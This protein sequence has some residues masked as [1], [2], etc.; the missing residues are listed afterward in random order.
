M[1]TVSNSLLL[2]TLATAVLTSA[3]DS[4]GETSTADYAAA[5]TCAPG[6]FRIAGTIDGM[7]VDVTEPSAGGGFAQDGEGGNLGTQNN[8]GDATDPART[9]LDLD[10]KPGLSVGD[11][12]PA[13]GTVRLA[14]PNLDGA[15]LCLGAGSSVRAIEDGVQFHLAKLS[16]GAGCAVA[17]VGSL[18]GCWR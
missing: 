9:N 18:D 7:S 6:T 11:I 12:G 10:W 15:T 2:L 16:S 13:N 1:R 4:T 3:C 14:A 17:R 5:L 8:G